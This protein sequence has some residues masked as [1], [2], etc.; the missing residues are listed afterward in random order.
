MRL[1]GCGMANL[2]LNLC[3]MAFWSIKEEEEPEF[4]KN[5]VLECWKVVKIM[6]GGQVNAK[7]VLGELIRC[8]FCVRLYW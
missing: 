1:N 7:I 6:W 5:S 4:V 8:Y 2:S 3:V